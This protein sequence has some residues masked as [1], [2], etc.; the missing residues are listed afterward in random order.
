MNYAGLYKTAL[1]KQE[2]K[3]ITPLK[4]VSLQDF[5]DLNAAIPRQEYIQ[6]T[7]PILTNSEIEQEGLQ[8]E[9]IETCDEYYFRFWHLFIPPIDT[10]EQLCISYDKTYVFIVAVIRCIII[11]IILKLY[12]DNVDMIGIKKWLFFVLIY[13]FIVNLLLLVYVMTK[14]QKY[15]KI[16]SEENIAS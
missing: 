3:P 6:L 2:E 7:R 4:A 8:E 1:I 15:T 14:H 12:Y 10:Y 9:E 16:S 5:K 13:F 11:G